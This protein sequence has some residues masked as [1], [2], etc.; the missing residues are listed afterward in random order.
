MDKIA[1]VEEARALMTEGKEWSIWR[2]LS[3]KR[4]VRGVADKGTAALDA[5][6][7]KVKATW[8]EALKSAYAELTTPSGD[9]DDP[10][11]AAEQ[12]FMQHQAR[13]IP[14]SLR[15]A[16]RRV[17]QAD[18]EAY[19][20]RMAAEETFDRAERRLS[21]SLARRG[22]E[23]AIKAYDLRYAAIAEAEAAQRAAEHG[24]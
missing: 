14:E 4:R 12:Q 9:D 17:K 1:E 5:M 15:L 16:A 18:D 3:E 24:V 20:A 7:S 23:E 8:S 13:D 11:A 22:A 2:W 19:R 6:E 21:A 10:F